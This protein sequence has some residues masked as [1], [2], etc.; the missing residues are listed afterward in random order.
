MTQNKAR[1]TIRPADLKRLARD[2]LGYSDLRPGQLDA[3]RAL[4]AGRDTLVVMPTGAGKSAIYQLAG[5]RL[6]GPTVV[7][8]PTISLQHDQAESMRSQPLPEAAVINS[9]VTRTR[10]REARA[11]L[12]RGAVEFLLLAPEQFRRHEILDDLRR[13]RP[14][15]FVVDEAHCISEWGHDFRPDY[16]SLDAIVQELG[17]PVVL[18]L[19]ATAAPEVRDEIVTRLG[20]RDP[21]V[22]VHGFDRP[23]LHLAV[24]MFTSEAEKTDAVLEAVAAA[25][26]PGLVYVA[27]RRHAEQLAAALSDG[28]ERALFYHG[29]LSARERESVHESFRSAPNDQAEVIVA[30]NAFGMG[31]DK[32]NVRFVFHYDIPESLDAYYQ[33][34]GRGGRDGERA[35]AILFYRPEDLSL[36]RFFA[37]GRVG[38]EEIQRVADAVAEADGP[39]PPEDLRARLA[40]SGA[41][42]TRAIA[43]LEETGAVAVLAGGAVQAVPAKMESAELASEAALADA[44]RRDHELARLEI[45][46]TFAEHDGCRRRFLLSYFGETL[47]EPCRFCDN[48]DAGRTEV[49]PQRRDRPFAV[50]SWV[51]HRRWGRGVVKSYDHDKMTVVFDQV[52]IKTLQTRTVVQR[53]LLQPL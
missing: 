28:G 36:R 2:V 20:M 42:V 51:R 47:A 39:L 23:N 32:P 31:V 37:G 7:V 50:K 27:T 3:V 43:G 53:R 13:A 25:Q 1:A 22:I 38:E 10:E 33:E 45:M 46:R 24:R 19:T 48:C 15:L 49:T 52:G 4:L 34:I 44:R 30:T 40:I 21:V 41:K 29:G 17:R 8:S 18:A 5:L 16:L 9:R 6:A 11:K 26:K 35:E 14:S 12:R